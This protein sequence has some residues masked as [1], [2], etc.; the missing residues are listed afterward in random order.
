MLDHLIKLVLQTKS[1]KKLSPCRSAP[2]HA[3]ATTSTSDR[4]VGG[5]WASRFEQAEVK[6]EEKASQWSSQ[7]SWLEASLKDIPRSIESV[8]GMRSIKSEQ[9]QVIPKVPCVNSLSPRGHS[10]NGNLV[11]SSTVGTMLPSVVTAPPDELQH[12]TSADAQSMFVNVSKLQPHLTY[13]AAHFNK[14][15]VSQLQSHATA[16]TPGVCQLPVKPILTARWDHT[17]QQP[18]GGYKKQDQDDRILSSDQTANPSFTP[19]APGGYG[20]PVP[21]NFAGCKTPENPS[22]Y[23]RGSYQ[24]EGLYPGQINPEQE[25]VRM[26][27]QQF[28][29]VFAPPP[30]PG[31]PSL[32]MQQQQQ[33]RQSSSLTSATWSAGVGN[34]TNDAVN[35]G[36]VPFTSP[37]N[38]SQRLTDQATG[39]TSGVVPGQSISDITPRYFYQVYNRPP[40]F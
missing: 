6:M 37:A 1:E 24:R 21:A 15:Q 3:D 33:Q 30:L 14:G 17:N 11:S 40:P 16:D 4:G 27:F 28:G 7:C 10:P 25:S 35:S 23:P 39:S 20:H 8:E 32:D 19:A 18:I 31:R 34:V 13:V 29:Y 5:K 22:V 12:Q 36:A 9:Q 38:S 2:G 26:R